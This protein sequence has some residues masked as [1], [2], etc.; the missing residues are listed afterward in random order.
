MNEKTE[1]VNH[2]AHYNQGGPKEADGTAQYEVIKV[3]E[4]WG[5]GFCFG[6]A[7]KYILRAPHKGSE[8][9]DLDKARWYLDRATFNGEKPSALQKRI[10]PEDVAE[11]WGLSKQLTDAVIWIAGGAAPRAILALDEHV[12]ERAAREV[13]ERS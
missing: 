12:I 1:M 11:A 6:N 7:L 8:S 10:N 2:P 4:A 9:V 13:R 5:L 3:I